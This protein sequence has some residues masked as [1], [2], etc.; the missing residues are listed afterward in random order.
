MTEFDE[1]CSSLL[2]EAKRFLEK[3]VETSA[4]EAKVAYCHSAILIGIS[5]L[6]AYV[7][8]IAE[9]FIIWKDIPLIEKSL[10]GEKEIELKNGVFRLTNK[11]RMY[12]LT[13]RIEY[14][15]RKFKSYA[16][17]GDSEPWWSDLK[18]SINLRNKLV[19]PKANL[20]IDEKQVRLLLQSVINC[21]TTLSEAIYNKEF[22]FKNLGLQ[23]KMTY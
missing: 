7:N 1:L 6:E 21:L 23:S 9:D 18:N 14:I 3:A 12:R 13:D 8:G 19:H 11:L 2:E 17:K 4:G 10:L 20:E 22:P 15:Y 5:S 16:L